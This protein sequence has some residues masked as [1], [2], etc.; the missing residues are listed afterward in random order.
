MAHADESDTAEFRPSRR[1]YVAF[2]SLCVVIL[3]AALDA[4]SLSTA[5]PVC[6]PQLNIEQIL[7]VTR[8]D[9]FQ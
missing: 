1:F 5:L 4:T 9:Y 2:G 6:V 7:T 3:A 8:L